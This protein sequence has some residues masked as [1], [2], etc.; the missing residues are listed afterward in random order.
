MPGGTPHKLAW[1]MRL[2]LEMQAAD[3]VLA[4]AARFIVLNEDEIADMLS[5]QIGTE[6][7]REIA[8]LIPNM[9]GDQELDAGK[10]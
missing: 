7:F 5:E 9:A 8:S 3:S 2:A 6:G 1:G 4:D 10:I